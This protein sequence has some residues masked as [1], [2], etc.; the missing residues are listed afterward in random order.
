MIQSEHLRINNWLH[1]NFGIP[2][3]IVGL[4]RL[5]NQVLPVISDGE[6]ER[7][8]SLSVLSP[9]EL[10]PDILEK[11][12]MELEYESEWTINYTHKSDAR[13]GYDYNKT[14]GWRMRF[15]GNHFEHIKYLH[16]LQNAIHALTGNELTY[17]P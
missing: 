6:K 1:L 15:L 7:I 2:V 17:K 16:Q 14:L 13:F 8:V 3:Q 4:Q 10:S 12:D 5:D 9:I 11:C